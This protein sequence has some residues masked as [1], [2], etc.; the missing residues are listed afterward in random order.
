MLLHISRGRCSRLADYMG[1]QLYNWLCRVEIG[2]KA[3][4]HIIVGAEEFTEL[5]EVVSLRVFYQKKVTSIN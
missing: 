3:R 4:T 2:S 1:N 5:Q